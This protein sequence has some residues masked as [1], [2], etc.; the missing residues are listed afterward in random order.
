MSEF[1]CPICGS[2]I[3]A[4]IYSKSLLGKVTVPPSKDMTV[5][6]YR[7]QNGHICLAGDQAMGDDWRNQRAA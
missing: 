1:I 4:R 5:V 7:C 2:S 3:L 6:A